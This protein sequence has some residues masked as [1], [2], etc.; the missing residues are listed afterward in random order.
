M[1]QPGGHG[2][3]V[4]SGSA[5]PGAN[6]SVAVS[7]DVQKPQAPQPPPAQQ[8]VPETLRAPQLPPAQQSVPETLSGPAGPG[9]KPAVSL[10]ESMLKLQDAVEQTK[11][12]PCGNSSMKKPAAAKAKST[13]SSSLKRPASKTMAKAKTKPKGKVPAKAKMSNQDKRAALLRI[14]PPA[15][16]KKFANGCSKCRERPL[17]TASCWRMRG[18]EI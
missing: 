2:Q 11:D 18:F 8:S 10:S 1:Q 14:I 13:K 12:T 17:C 9:S 3:G 16:K 15:L 5:C 6:P 7:F 4:V